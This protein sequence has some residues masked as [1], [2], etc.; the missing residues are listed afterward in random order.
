MQKLKVTAN[1]TFYYCAPS[2]PGKITLT[3]SRPNS[4]QPILQAGA[5]DS[6]RE[7]DLPKVTQAVSGRT[8]N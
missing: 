1:D 7:S 2:R 4:K 8:R 3:F 5:E 6:E